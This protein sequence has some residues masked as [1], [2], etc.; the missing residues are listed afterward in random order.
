MD[1]SDSTAIPVSA[2]INSPQLQPPAPKNDKKPEQQESAVVK[3]SAEG[4]RMNRAE[5]QNNSTERAETRPQKAAEPPGIKFMEGDN[6]GGN[7]NT[8]A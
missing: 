4:Q 8:F 2:P 6:R 5:N 1:V 3:L 7:V